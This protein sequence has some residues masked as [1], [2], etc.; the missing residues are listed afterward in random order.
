MSTIQIKILLAILLASPFAFA[1]SQRNESLES[2]CLKSEK[3][4]FEFNTTPRKKT[5]SLCEG[6]KQ[7]YLVYRYGRPGKPEIQYPLILD[8]N[9]W[10][11]FNLD[12]YSRGGGIGNDAMGDYS[13]SFTNIDTEY[14]IT[15]NWRLATNEYYIGIIIKTPTKQYV[16]HGDPKTQIG[17]LLLLGNRI[18]LD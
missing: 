1:D 17:S 14:I 15:Q 16:V 11:K 12:G 18:Q 8:E 3:T 4:I 13:L 5:V 7:N 2:H 10:G 9:S 6:E